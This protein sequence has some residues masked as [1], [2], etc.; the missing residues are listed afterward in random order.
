MTNLISS[1]ALSNLMFSHRLRSHS[2]LL[3]HQMAVSVDGHAVFGPGPLQ[4]WILAA[5]V[6]ID[7]AQGALWGAV[8]AVL[9]VLAVRAAWRGAE[10]AWA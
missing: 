3:G 9:A 1:L 8:I 5:P 6:H 10:A 4:S 7:P 2:P